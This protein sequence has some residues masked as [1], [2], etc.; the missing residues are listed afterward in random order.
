MVRFW[1]QV[2]LEKSK[3]SVIIISM[4]I[5]HLIIFLCN[6]IFCVKS[7]KLQAKLGYSVNSPT[8]LGSA[9][10]KSA[11]TSYIRSL[12]FSPDG[13]QIAAVSGCHL[14]YSVIYQYMQMLVLFNIS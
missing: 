5:S 6:Q 9:T 4:T 1:Q 13:S 10:A 14:N 2:P 7:G 11:S 12:S 3:F 8:S